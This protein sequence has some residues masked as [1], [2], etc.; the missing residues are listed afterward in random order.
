MR[1]KI[2]F[3][4]LGIMFAS[5]L[6]YCVAACLLVASRGAD[7]IGALIFTAAIILVL[8]VFA[9]ALSAHAI[10]RRLVD[11]LNQLPVQP[12]QAEELAPEFAP[13]IRRMTH[14]NE[15]FVQQMQTLQQQH[16][17][18]DRMRR[19]FTANVS[20][21]LK[22]PLTSIS[23]YA[24]LIE[25]GI[26]KPEDIP[27]FAGKIHTESQRLITLVSDIIKLSQLDDRDIAIEIRELNLAEL[28]RN[29]FSY[30][31]L[32]AEEKGVTLELIGEN[33]T[34]RGAEEI[35][36]EMIY[37]LCDNAIKYNHP[38]GKVTVELRQHIDGVELAVSDT[39][40]GIPKEDIPRIFERFYRV[41]KSH[42]KEVGGT[43]LGLSIVKHGARFLG[44]SVTAE[45]ELG[46]GTTIRILF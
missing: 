35:V 33:P 8:G 2:L 11:I 18:Q 6:L 29:V 30:L 34:I 9:C 20:H 22:T 25:S 17:T 32:A 40:I 4:H 27:R 38:G 36:E 1:K 43:G 28:C 13:L 15:Q 23:G 42:S 26:A 44:A 10:T 3:A 39:G 41:D 5:I 21:E 19:D 24:E 31:E 7:A 46:E 16:E 37:N 12:T 14:Q 45:S